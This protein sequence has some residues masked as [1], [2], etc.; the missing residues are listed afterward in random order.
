M[1][2]GLTYDLL[3]DYLALGYS[4]EQAAEFD[5]PE[6]IAAI[7]STLNGMGHTTERIGHVHHLVTALAAGRRWD[8][9]FNIAEGLYGFG[10]EAQVPA[11]LDAY[12]IPYVFSDPL[13]LSLALHK[14]MAKRVVRDAGLPTADF[15]VVSHLSDVAGVALPYPLFAKPVAEG[16]SKGVTPRSRIGSPDELAA[17]CAE[18]LARY[19]QPVLVETYLPGRE[20]TVGITGTGSAAEVLGVLEVS[21][22]AGADAG[23]YSF[24]NKDHYESLV[25]Y[26]LVQD[27]VA[28]RVAE[29]ALAVWRVLG[30][31]D[32]GR[33][34][35][36]LDAQGQ[37]NFLEVNPLAGLHPVR[38]D[39]VILAGQL[40]LSYATLIGRIVD[41]ALRRLGPV[42]SLPPVW[43]PRGEAGHAAQQ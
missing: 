7:E 41:S 38:S 27:A 19:D 12:G 4:K 11:L 26:R 32:G 3:G 39:I 5:A 34:D 17:V 42:A 43:A 22:N 15:A 21:L 6:T 25:D 1:R 16:T 10:R 33:V 35:V 31:R 14:G 37:P 18:L 9:V 36:R 28:H 30:C 8:L 40:G 13:V 24:H 23:F 20:F 2:I 29:H